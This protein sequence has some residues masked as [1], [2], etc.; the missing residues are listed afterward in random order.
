MLSETLW[1]LTAPE[2]PSFAALVAPLPGSVWNSSGREDGPNANQI[3][4][5]CWLRKTWSGVEHFQAPGSQDWTLKNQQFLFGKKTTRT[6]SLND[7]TSCVT[8]A[9]ALSN[10]GWTIIELTI[11]HPNAITRF[12]KNIPRIAYVPPHQ[13]RE[14]HTTIYNL[15]ELTV[16]SSVIGMRGPHKGNEGEAWLHHPRIRRGITPQAHTATWMHGAQND[17]M[18]K[19]ST[20]SCTSAT[21]LEE[22]LQ[23]HPAHLV[24]PHVAFVHPFA[25]SGLCYCQVFIVVHDAQLF[26]G[27]GH[28]NANEK[29][30]KQPGRKQ[31]GEPMGT[32]CR[33]NPCSPLRSQRNIHKAT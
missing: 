8:S 10:K 4:S 27:L 5:A 3:L 9:P 30:Q 21:G 23:H 32:L 1:P 26:W 17:N 12:T 24:L 18:H 6:C 2:T 28:C 16:W 13:P 14:S 29:G 22:H 20:H 33:P 31:P 25:W 15:N 19:G 7:R 11:A